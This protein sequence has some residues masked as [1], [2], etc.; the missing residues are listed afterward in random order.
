MRRKILAI[1]LLAVFVIDIVRPSV[2]MALSSGPDQPEFSGFTPFGADDFVDPFTGDFNYNL[3]L[4]VVPGYQGGYPVNL[5]Y[6]SGVSPEQEA[7]WVGLG[8]NLNPG[9][10]SRNLRGLPDEFNANDKVTVERS[11]KPNVTMSVNVGQSVSGEALGVEVSDFLTVG[12]SVNGSLTMTY[13]NYTG[14]SHSYGMGINVSAQNIPGI[15]PS[16]GLNANMGPNGLDLSPNVGVAAGFSNKSK[17]I[18]AGVNGSMSMTINS[19]TGVERVGFSIEPEV[20]ATKAVER[21]NKKTGKTTKTE[22]S[23]DLASK[24]PGG[25]GLGMSFA[26]SNPAPFA[27][28]PRKQESITGQGHI[29]VAANG[30]TVD[31]SMQFTWNQSKFAKKKIDYKAFGYLHSEDY[32]EG[33]SMM[34][35]NKL[36]D[37]QAT[38]NSKVISAP[39]ATPDL[40]SVTNQFFTSNVRA[41]RTDVGIYKDPVVKSTGSGMTFGVEAEPDVTG[42]GT[43][44]GGNF[45]SD[46]TDSYSG[47]W[48]DSR[49]DYFH[50]SYDFTSTDV[51][52]I[53]AGKATPNFPNK[54]NEY[55]ESYYFM[56]D[57]EFT[58]STENTYS[59]SALVSSAPVVPKLSPIGSSLPELGHSLPMTTPSFVTDRGG[60]SNVP[61]HRTKRQYRKKAFQFFSWNDFKDRTGNY[62]TTN[63]PSNANDNHFALIAATTEDGSRFLYGKPLYV[64]KDKSVSFSVN[65][66]TIHSD[67]FLKHIRYEADKDNTTGNSKGGD[68]YFNSTSKSP[69]ISK[70]LLT[71]IVSPDYLDTENPSANPFDPTL[72]FKD[73]GEWVK[74]DYET[75]NS[76]AKYRNPMTVALDKA[77]YSPGNYSDPTDD[78]ASYTYGEKETNYL[79]EIVTKTHKA[80]FITST[81]K[82]NL[83]A[84]GENGG[85][86]TTGSFSKKLDEIKLYTVAPDGTEDKLLKTIKFTYDYLLCFNTPNSDASAPL[87]TN[88]PSD[89][90][91]EALKQGKLTLLKVEVL[92]GPELI[93][94]DVY[95]FGYRGVNKAGTETY[96]YDDSKVDRWG[97]YQTNRFD[98]GATGLSLFPYTNQDPS[99]YGENFE[100]DAFSLNKITLPTGGEIHVEYESDDYGYVEDKLA[101]SMY[102]VA[103]FSST[104]TSYSSSNVLNKNTK[105][106][107][108][109]LPPMPTGVT[110]SDLGLTPRSMIQGL[111]DLYFKVFMQLKKKD[112]SST[113]AED[114]VEG[115]AELDGVG[116]SNQWLTTTTQS[117]GTKYALAV[118]VKNVKLDKSGS[119][120]PIRKASWQNMRY[121]RSD[122][123]RKPN[124][125]AGAAQSFTDLI[126]V[127]PQFLNL[128]DEMVKMIK[129]YYA[130]AQMRYAKKANLTDSNRPSYVKLNAFNRTKK[131]GGTRVKRLWLDDKWSTMTGV[132]NGSNIHGTEYYY[133]HPDGKT[134][135]VAAYEPI[136]GSEEIPHK[137][138]IRYGNDVKFS[139]RDNAFYIDDPILEAFYPAPQVGY[140]RVIAKPISDFGNI[141]DPSDIDRYYVNSSAY[142]DADFADTR[143]AIMEHRFY[144][145]KNF[146]VKVRKTKLNATKEDPPQ[147]VIPFVGTKKYTVEGYSQGFSVET[148]DMHGKKLMESTYP[149]TTNISELTVM[150][151]TNKVEYFYNVKVHAGVI[152]TDLPTQKSKGGTLDDLFVGNTHFGITSEYYGAARESWTYS[153]SDDIGINVHLWFP[154]VPIVI[155]V[156]KVNLSKTE[157]TYRELATM[158]VIRKK[159]VLVQTRSTVNQSLSIAEPVTFDEFTGEPILTKNTNEYNE[160]LLNY[161]FKG[162][163]LVPQYQP[164]S[165]DLN[166]RLSYIGLTNPAQVMAAFKVLWHVYFDGPG[167]EYEDNWNGFWNDYGKQFI[168]DVSEL[169]H[170]DLVSLSDVNVTV[171]ST[172]EVVSA[173]KTNKFLW[174]RKPGANSAAFD[175]IDKDGTVHSR[176]TYLSNTF[177]VSNYDVSTGLVDC[178]ELDWAHNGNAGNPNNPNDPNDPYVPISLEYRDLDNDAIKA[179]SSEIIREF[180][181]SFITV[182]DPAEKNKLQEELFNVTSLDELCGLQTVLPNSNFWQYQAFVDTD[183]SA[184][185][186]NQIM[187]NGYQ[188][189]NS[190]NQSNSQTVTFQGNNPSVS[191]EVRVVYDDYANRVSILMD[192]RIEGG[193]SESYSCVYHFIFLAPI[194]LAEVNAYDQIVDVQGGIVYFSNGVNT[195]Q[196]EFTP[197]EDCAPS[198]ALGLCSS[199]I[200]SSSGVEF[201]EPAAYVKDSDLEKD[202]SSVPSGLNQFTSGKDNRLYPLVSNVYRAEERKATPNNNLIAGVT[203]FD[204]DGSADG[205]FGGWTFPDVTGTSAYAG[206]VP[207]STVTKVSSSGIMLEQKDAAGIPSTIQYNYDKRLVDATCANCGY[208]EFGYESFE[209]F[210]TTYNASSTTSVNSRILITGGGT[211]S[212]TESH[213]GNNSL[214]FTTASLGAKVQLDASNGSTNG[215]Q[216][217]T[218]KKYVMSFWIKPNLSSYVQINQTMNGGGATAP[219]VQYQFN[220]LNSIDGWIRIE[221]EFTYGSTGEQLGIQSSGDFYIDDLRIY[222][223]DGMVKSYVYNDYRKPEAV[224]DENNYA[225]FYYYNSRQ[226][227]VTVNKETTQ[228]ILTV[229]TGYKNKQKTN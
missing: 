224:L 59:P 219:S 136:V 108:V 56:A 134:S 37:V 147:Q 128:F 38:G 7:S 6:S 62:Y 164:K 54:L 217:E 188:I 83:S 216:L 180:S 23:S 68:N 225:T 26:Q 51:L 46:K 90:P 102:K 25:V 50:Q 124:T 74:F 178:Q 203:N 9:A 212:T 40:W 190:N 220:D 197:A 158:K 206:W 52:N 80:V 145:A 142:S 185:I 81:R 140:E 131:G 18:E 137:K 65:S 192:N 42:P 139:S 66:P 87:S 97:T 199:S 103:G 117:G 213:S 33:E 173:P 215:L 129:G 106:I 104:G 138:P 41:Y 126:T 73:A 177:S 64:T 69:Y 96:K 35:F 163:H 221:H 85:V 182:V 175:L 161:A 28:F 151:P 14:L 125:A 2:S 105:Y 20:T 120:N 155:P 70:M 75:N 222:P 200:L 91:S 3:P 127:F 4:L 154:I 189:L 29:G 135:G 110:P 55:N 184:G 133:T 84:S 100:G 152:K 58:S 99:V 165:L 53:L 24:V 86:N 32:E 119:A 27:D 30:I 57:D 43:K 146:P 15:T 183:I 92:A 202:L 169:T 130:F 8:W 116:N 113:I 159:S 166:K 176:S 17:S 141:I 111:D 191:F 22:V 172:G 107:I 77:N 79:K 207:K 153:S 157:H 122:L 98:G 210:G 156:P 115:Y 76:I 187:N 49:K 227:L 36:N 198:N 214:L 1:A 174:V 45:K 160:E 194:T 168:P 123:F 48:R 71:K 94:E 144:T 149:Y 196:A 21:K 34:D 12:P 13:N 5:S 162:H 211:L 179:K 63:K 205:T 150:T 31:N 229:K 170:G 16:V 193:V 186:Y 101:T 72:D 209:S 10:I 121:R 218:N 114:Y 39:Q 88:I 223:A 143:S 204:Y 201:A 118:K 112:G 61:T 228:G 67:Q 181:K 89:Y 78:K 11:M 148:N 44:V 171:N 95:K 167:L 19:N 109:D 195:I 47:P 226:D 60:V 208:K 132:N 82:D 93:Q